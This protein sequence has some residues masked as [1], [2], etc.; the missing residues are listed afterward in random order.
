VDEIWTVNCVPGSYTFSFSNTLAPTALHILDPNNANNSAVTQLS[1]TVDT[2]GDGIPDNVENACG[3]NPNSGL[4]IPERVDGIYAGTDNDGDTQID[5]ALPGGA[6]TFDCDRDGYTGTS[7]GHVYNPSIQGDQDPCG[8]NNT[9]PTSPPSP[10]GWPADL[11][12]GGIPNST[13]FVNI[14]DITSF[15]APVRYINS[16]VGDHTGDRRWDLVPG[17]GLFFFDININDLSN[18]I[19]VVP[20]MLNGPRALNGPQCPFPP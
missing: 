6:A 12:G 18:L 4:S 11:Q 3:S 9:P 2:D 8:T 14:L 17:S 10:I 19:V 7:E 16:D 13:N 5:E 1:V 20:P 15:I